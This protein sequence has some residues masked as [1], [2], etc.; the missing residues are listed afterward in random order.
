MVLKHMVDAR[1]RELLST[2][3]ELEKAN[4]TLQKVYSD[5]LEKLSLAA[6]Y[7]DDDTGEHTRRVAQLSYLTA[8]AMGFTQQ[9]AEL[10]LEAARL[11]DIGK[12]G[13][14]DNVLLKPG[15]LNES[16][17]RIMKKHCEIGASLLRGG[18]SKLLA[19]AESIALTHHERWD[20]M[21]YPAGLREEQIPIEGRIVALADLFDAL[22]HHRGYR[23]AWP[24]EQ[25][26]KLINDERGKS[27][28]PNVVD[29]FLQVV[30]NAPDSQ[31]IAVSASKL[32]RRE[33][34]MKS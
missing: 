19:I 32:N 9:D 34:L 2:N 7:R 3:A 1:T 15:K 8:V 14:P 30:V 20:G 33:V 26:L 13:I 27:F 29:V 25:V 10:I 21:G 12:I 23:P 24:K 22:M 28:D 5:M 18:D 31:P 6:E 16:E 17:M 11:H 4:L